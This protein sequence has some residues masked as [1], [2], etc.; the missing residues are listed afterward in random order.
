MVHRDVLTY[1]S[2]FFRDAYSRATPESGQRKI[3]LPEADP[4]TFTSYLQW[5]Y[6]RQVVFS[7]RPDDD[8]ND[9][10]CSL[11]HLYTLAEFVRNIPL[12]NAVVDKFLDVL[13][14]EIESPSVNSI[15]HLWSKAAAGCKLRRAVVDWFLFY[16]RGNWLQELR[17]S[18]PEAFLA[19]LAVEFAKANWD[20]HTIIDPLTAS[21]VNYHELDPDSSRSLLGDLDQ[22]FSRIL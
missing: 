20:I 22:R 5:A 13:R 19:D 1:Q 11:S 18:L 12:K 17:G 16:P 6:R 3:T 4:E 15:R 21:R 9:K 7:T 2:P 10:L 8:E 14:A